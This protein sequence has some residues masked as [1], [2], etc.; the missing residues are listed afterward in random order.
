DR[1]LSRVDKLGNS[2]A[3]A[4]NTYSLPGVLG[5]SPLDETGFMQGHPDKFDPSE[6]VT[7]AVV[8]IGSGI[9]QIQRVPKSIS[10]TMRPVTVTIT[11]DE[12]AN[13][14]DTVYRERA[15]DK[16]IVTRVQEFRN[17]IAQ[18]PDTIYRPFKA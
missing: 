4:F 18:P 6:Y 3:K 10:P 5:Y 7:A 9:L 11:A 1:D 12:V 17:A 8:P 13:M 14:L 2:I 16:G 15:D